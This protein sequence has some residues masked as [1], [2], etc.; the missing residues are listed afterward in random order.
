MMRKRGLMP[1]LNMDDILDEDMAFKRTP[2][3]PFALGWM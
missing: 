3:S 1:G 2:S